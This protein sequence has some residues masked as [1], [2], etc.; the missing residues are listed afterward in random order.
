MS[1][2]TLQSKI[3]ELTGELRRRAGEL[4]TKTSFEIQGRI[5]V[6]MSGSKHG[7]IYKRGSKTHQASAPREA[8]AIDF[9]GVGY[10][11]LGSSESEVRQVVGTN[12]EY[13]AILEFGGAHIEPRPYFGPAFEAARPGFEKGMKE[14][15]K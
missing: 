14:L 12:M 13:A 15:I 6:S 8:P 1:N 3:P 2:F 11:I 9:G 7:R 5:R 4:V 10:L